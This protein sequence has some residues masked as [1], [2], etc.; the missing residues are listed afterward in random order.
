MAAGVHHPFV[1]GAIRHVVGFGDWQGVDVCTQGYGGPGALSAFYFSNQA[2]A[3]DFAV[4][5][6]QSVQLPGDV[7]LSI[8]F[9]KA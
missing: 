7:A 4:R 2:R 9:L 1:L 8:V 3:G 6:T 5:D